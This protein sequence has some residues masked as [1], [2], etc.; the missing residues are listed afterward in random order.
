[1]LLA[2]LVALVA[3]NTDEVKLDWVIGSGEAALAWIVLVAAVL[4]WVLGIA[5]GVIIRRRTRRRA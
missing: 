1:V 2:I 4:G 5:T 3:A